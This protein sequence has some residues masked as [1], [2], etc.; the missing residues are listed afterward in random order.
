M[1]QD[2]QN[3]KTRLKPSFGQMGHK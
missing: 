1:V 3:V 2:T